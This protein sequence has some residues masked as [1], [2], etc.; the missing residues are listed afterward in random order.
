MGFYCTVYMDV[1]TDVS[2]FT[3]RRVHPRWVSTFCGCPSGK[4]VSS[5]LKWLSPSKGYCLCGCPSYMSVMSVLH[6][7][8]CFIRIYV[9]KVVHNVSISDKLK[10][11]IFISMWGLLSWVIFSIHGWRFYMIARSENVHFHMAVPLEAVP[12]IKLFLFLF[13]VHSSRSFG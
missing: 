3:V 9:R 1:L 12:F 6:A 2:I 11:S 10:R 7:C 5:C 8:P 4:Q 13:F